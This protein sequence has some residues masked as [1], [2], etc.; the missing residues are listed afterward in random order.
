MF[1]YVGVFMSMFLAVT[2]D[3]VLCSGLVARQLVCLW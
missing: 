1:A 2:F 3:G